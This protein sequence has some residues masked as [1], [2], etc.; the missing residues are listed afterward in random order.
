MRDLLLGREP[1]DF[2]VATSAS[3][4]V[5]RQLFP[6]TIPVGVQFGVMIVLHEGVQ[7]QVATF[8]SDGEYGDGRHPSSVQFSDARE[9]SLRRDFTINGLFYDP[10]RDQILDFVGGQADLRAKVIRCI[11]D[12]YVRFLEDHLR[13]MRAV[14]FA[15]I[16]DF[17]I[18]KKTWEAV[19]ELHEKIQ[20][21]SAERVRDELE[22]MMVSER[23]VR[24]LDLL[25]ESGLLAVILPEVVQLKGCEQPRDFHP[26]GDVFVHTRLALEL[27]A[28]DA[29]LTLV[30][31]TLFHDIGKPRTRSV[32]ENGRIRFN[33]H[34]RVGAEMAEQILRR[35]RFPNAVI[36]RVTEA[37]RNHMAFK[38]TPN[39]R[40]AKLRRF[41]ARTNFE[42][43]LQLHRADCLASHGS[44]EIYDFL[45][46]KKQEFAQ[47]AALPPPI[48][49]GDDLI[50][51]GLKPGPIFKTILEEAQNLH[52]EGKLSS[53][54]EALNW[55]QKNLANL[56]KK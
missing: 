54:Q 56:E 45:I 26:E 34:E 8:R 27:L 16:L 9:D 11:G 3:P 15:S 32:D 50:Q 14:R 2:D 7:T 40:V 23:R 41:L 52:L 29:S 18:E 21:V 5:I 33:H 51:L 39:M 17:S 20:Q 35:L 24:A 19:C 4:E 38:D 47:E 53:R 43:E 13:L 6:H 36:E 22:K 30:L 37:V 25:D 28:S 44:L 10:V 31:S 42:E 49:R 46:Q 48:L 55:V 1:H 12:P